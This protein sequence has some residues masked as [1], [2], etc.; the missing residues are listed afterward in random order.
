MLV[1]V[2]LVL[3]G[4]CCSRAICALEHTEAP[5]TLSAIG[6]LWP[7]RVLA[8]CCALGALRDIGASVALGAR[9]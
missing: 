7:L 9:H 4:C 8:V 3:L 1:V 6:A 2:L 5:M